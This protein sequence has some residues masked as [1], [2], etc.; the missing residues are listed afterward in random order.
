MPKSHGMF[1]TPEY[2]SWAAMKSRCSNPNDHTWHDYGRVGIRVCDRWQKFENF[3]ADMGPRPPGTSLDRIDNARGY[4]P[5]NCRWA[6]NKQQSENRRSTTFVEWR[7]QRATVSEW[8][9]RMGMSQAALWFR[10]K[11]WPVERAMS[12]PRHA[13]MDRFKQ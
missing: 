8:A 7:G 2:R 6:T 10:L 4:D 1:G 12:E 5:G 9:K 3:F 11:R 13:S